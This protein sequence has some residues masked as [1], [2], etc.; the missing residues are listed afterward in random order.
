MMKTRNTLLS[1]AV[2]A[3]LQLPAVALAQSAPPQLEEVLVTAQ[4][5]AQRFSDVGISGTAYSGESLAEAGVTQLTDLALLTPNVQ[6][7]DV[8][9]NSIPN[10]TIRGIGLND[11]A[12]NN[13]PAAGIY[14][15]DVYLVSPAMLSFGM[16]DLERVEVL[17]G[18]QGTLFGRNTTAGTV[19][20][21]SKKPSDELDGYFTV[22][23]GNYERILA[24]GA[25]GGPITD[26]LA[27]RIAIQTVQQG[28]GFQTNR[29][30]GEK[31]GEIDRTSA[32]GQLEW[33]PSDDLGVLLSV[34]GGN[35]KSDVWLIKIDNPFTTEDD[36]DTNPYRSG[37]SND[38]HMDNETT[39]ANLT[40]NW[41]MS[42]A[43]TLT[44]ITGYQD[45]SRFIVEDRDGASLIMLDGTFDNQIDQFSQEV[46]LTHVGDELVLIGGVFYGEDS[47]DT[48]DEFLATDLLAL[49][50]LA[51]VDVIGNE[52]K[53]DTT[54]A[55]LFLQSEWS[56]NPSWKLT[57]G[58][59]YTDE[60]KDFSGAYTF[61]IAGGV[62][63]PLYPDVVEEFS[64]D[65]VSGKLGIDYTGI[66]NTLL[67]ASVSRG[68]K[69]GGFQG[70][71][72]F[73]PAALLPFDDETVLAYEAGMKTRRLG[74]SLELN[75]SVFFYDY[76]DMQ[77]YG[78][79]FDSPVG[80]LFGITN[81]GDAEVKGA[82]ADLWWRPT[83]GLDL[84]FGLG[85]LDTE[86]TRSVVD[87]VATGSELPNAP[88]IT[89]SS[90]IGYEW[91]ITGAL[92]ANV[93][94]GADF[95]DS[96]S[97]DII[98]N[99]PQAQEGSYW[100]Y[101]ARVGIGAADDRWDISLWG[102]NLA[103]EQYRSQVIF[104]SVGYGETW[105]MP[106]TYGVTFSMRM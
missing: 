98:R 44:S 89:F 61:L 66:E 87:G 26:T 54:S 50:G 7:K 24:E 82:E 103:D 70:Q 30:N 95:Q 79:L 60:S 31:I 3:A 90:M 37:A 71:L 88:E 59:R 74:N 40:V 63:A 96:V 9:G 39:G 21:I 2:L 25:V 23:A 106:R 78:G 32:R 80:V 4:K 18:P 64:T 17:K 85:W 68:F 22:E 93:A 76:E 49:L 33:T 41:S 5:R 105:G 53:Q 102:K 11:Y 10:V 77:F 47:V 34:Y 92:M 45:F 55:A 27:G 99:P 19:S 100:L 86:I 62:E 8:M 52:Y 35:D 29:V 43:L 42:D 83:E 13:N 14:I 73:D 28:E 57:A 81:V 51:G 75:A 15:D 12:A 20:F 1:T 104:S 91:P 84:R 72:S 16:F 6:I 46:R 38:P 65:N 56:F 36:G 97:Y 94:F 101:D 69:S 58:A 48:R 67:Y